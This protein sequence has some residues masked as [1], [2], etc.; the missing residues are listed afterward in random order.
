MSD[1]TFS[2]VASFRKVFTS[3]E[4]EQKSIYVAIV[5]IRDLPDEIE[6]WLTINPREA[7]R[8]SGVARKI[9]ASLVNDPSAFVF[10]N[11]GLTLIAQKIRFDNQSGK[12]SLE[13]KDSAIHGLLDGGHTYRVIRAELTETEDDRDDLANAYVRVEMLE[14]FSDLNEVVDIVDARNRSAQ[15]KEQSLEEL[16]SH[17]EAIKVVLRDQPY[18]HRIAYKETELLDDGTK[19]DLDIKEIL[20]YLICF[21]AETFTDTK[22][23][24]VAYSGKASALKHYADNR[25]RLERYIGLLPKILQLVDTIHLELPAA[26]IAQGGRFGRLTGVVTIKSAKNNIE[27]PY[28]GAKS[29]YQIP[30]GFIYPVLAAFRPLVN[31][32]KKECSWKSDPIKLFEDIKETLAQAICEQAIEFR[33]PNK[34]GKDGATWRLCYALAA[35]EVAKRGNA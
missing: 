31:I 18:A 14:G 17:F 6:D 16:R 2:R 8:T 9:Q 10:R 27:L 15:V 7:T 29:E 4:G 19:K 13:M 26:Y 24:I 35:L 23:P 34:L 3:P 22:H 5:N 30:S 28:I 25:T 1:I 33:N 21:D 12:V 11:R 20:S 32:G